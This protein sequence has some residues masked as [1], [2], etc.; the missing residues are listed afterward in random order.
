MTLDDKEYLVDRDNLREGIQMK[1]SK[2]QK[3]FSEISAAFLNA[4]LNFK[5]LPKKDDPDSWS[6]SGNTGSEKNGEINI[7]KAVFQR[8]LR[9]TIRK[10]C[11]NT[12]AIWMTARLQYLL[13]TV[14]VVA[15]EKVS[16]SDTQNSK[17]V[18]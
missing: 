2:N 3:T 8:T 14:K 12:I 13:I 18:W 15:F 17:A 1:L 4:L 10:M 6:I 11:R 5:H 9:Q 16:F 7:Q